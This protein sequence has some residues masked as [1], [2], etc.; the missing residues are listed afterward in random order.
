MTI[1]SDYDF[2]IIQTIYHSQRLHMNTSHAQFIASMLKSLFND[3]AHTGQMSPRLSYKVNYTF[4]RI[5]IG[6]EII[7]KQHPIFRS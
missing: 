4:C 2:A 7:N 6:Q 3:K 1:L 5:A